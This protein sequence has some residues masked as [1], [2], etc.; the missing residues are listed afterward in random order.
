[1]I[2]TLH[3]QPH[4][5]AVLEAPPLYVVVL[6]VPTDVTVYRTLDLFEADDS[7]I[8]RLEIYTQT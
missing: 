2:G 7:G 5:Q 4:V 6:D 3:P 8:R 1:M